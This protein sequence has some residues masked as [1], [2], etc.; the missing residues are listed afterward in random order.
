MV[1]DEGLQ[2]EL[3]PA[4]PADNTTPEFAL[5]TDQLSLGYAKEI[6]FEA[7]KLD[8]PIE[9]SKYEPLIE[10]GGTEQNMALFRN[11]QNGYWWK[12]YEGSGSGLSGIVLA[13]KGRAE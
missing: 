4:R 12:V 1:R 10:V 9:G 13:V 5:V 3:Q 7:G 2:K 6:Y 8:E 11:C